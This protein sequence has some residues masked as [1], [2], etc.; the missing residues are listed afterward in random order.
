MYV[1][2]YRSQLKASVCD[3]RSHDESQ[4]EGRAYAELISFTERRIENWDFIFKLSELQRF[5]EDYLQDLGFKK[6]ISKTTL[7][8]QLFEYSTW[9]TLTIFDYLV[10]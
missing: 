7:K 3:K 1:C 2:M 5:Y 8:M 4:I 9:K 10:S 6:S